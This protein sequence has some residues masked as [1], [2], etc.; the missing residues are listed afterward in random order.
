MRKE[1]EK[2]GDYK[3][4]TMGGKPPPPQTMPPPAVVPKQEANATPPPKTKGARG[5]GGGKGN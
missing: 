4:S 2:I 1:S 5:R 3:V